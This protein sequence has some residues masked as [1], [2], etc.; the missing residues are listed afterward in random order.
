MVTKNKVSA[1][2]VDMAV[3]QISEHMPAYRIAQVC[4]ILKIYF[5]QRAARPTSSASAVSAKLEKRQSLLGEDD[6]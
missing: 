5:M 3:T 6:K 2:K 1:C 4:L